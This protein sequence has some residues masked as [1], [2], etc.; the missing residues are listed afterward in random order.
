MSNP[1]EVV[2]HWFKKLFGWVIKS[3]P[4]KELVAHLLPVAIEQVT[5]LASISSLSSSQKRDAAVSALK[6]AAQSQGLQ[7]ADHMLALL[8]ELAVAKLKGTIGV[9]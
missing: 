8:V 7:F 5:S 1:F 2:G 9:E 3:D 4:F 6:S